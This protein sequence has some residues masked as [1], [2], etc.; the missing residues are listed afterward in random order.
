MEPNLYDSVVIQAAM[1]RNASIVNPKNL[2]VS[3][4]AVHFY[5]I[6]CASNQDVA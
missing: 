6:A 3:R 4:K 2:S 1:G 5:S